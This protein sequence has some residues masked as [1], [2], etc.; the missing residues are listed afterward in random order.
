MCLAV[1][2]TSVDSSVVVPSIEQKAAPTVVEESV[3][4][5]DENGEEV[6]IDAGDIIVTPYSEKD[7]LSAEDK[8]NIDAAYEQILG[9]ESLAEL[10][11]N[12]DDD[13]TAAYL[14]DINVTG[15]AQEILDRGGSVTVEMDVNL[16]GASKVKVLHNYESTHWREEPSEVV[17]ENRLKITF[18]SH[19]P[20]IITV[21]S[22]STILVTEPV[23]GTL[24]DS[25]VDTFT[26][27]TTTS[28][29]MPLI[30]GG[31]ACILVAGVLLVVANRKKTK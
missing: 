20:F 8:E 19:S 28:S 17:A 24:G 14:F 9:T 6:E 13:D 10:H 25:T 5:T 15:E 12:M 22:D 26:S 31:V 29:T 7:T 4:A 18:T 23:E 16:G 1:V 30:V 3:T 27:S 2:A 21:S 11:E